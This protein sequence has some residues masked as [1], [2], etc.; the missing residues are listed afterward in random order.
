MR[1]RRIARSFNKHFLSSCVLWG[2]LRARSVRSAVKAMGPWPRRTELAWNQAL[3]DMRS[4]GGSTSHPG[5][6][7]GF[8]LGLAKPQ[9]PYSQDGNNPGSGQHP[10]A[11]WGGSYHWA[12]KVTLAL[13]EAPLPPATC[14]F[15]Q[16][17]PDLDS[18]HHLATHPL[19]TLGI[20]AAPQ[21]SYLNGATTD[22]LGLT[23]ESA[24]VPRGECFVS[25]QAVATGL[26]VVRLCHPRMYTTL[27]PV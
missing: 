2:S 6:I 4:A 9:L 13:P 23:R 27:G 25:F 14:Q 21:S 22:L 26:T 8:N 20:I 24:E 16:E 11:R 5:T 10:A 1:F 12:A 3:S 18:A 15:S 17:S 19:V 7:C